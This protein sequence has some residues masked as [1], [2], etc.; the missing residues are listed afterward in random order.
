MGHAAASACIT[1]LAGVPLTPTPGIYSRSNRDDAH[2]ALIRREREVFGGLAPIAPAASATAPS[3]DDGAGAS[4][5]AAALDV[6]PEDLEYL[7]MDVWGG[8]CVLSGACMGGGGPSL[9]LTR[10]DRWQPAS[11][12]NLVLLAKPLAEVHDRAVDPFAELPSGLV[13]AVKATLERA[14]RERAV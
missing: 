2:R 9:V 1:S 5:S 10:W 12:G 11:V 3:G 6:W 14:S 4:S 7:V 13:Q 8:R